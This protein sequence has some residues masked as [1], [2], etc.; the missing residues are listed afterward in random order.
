M[1][2]APRSR[3]AQE[4][5]E[6]P[7]DTRIYSASQRGYTKAWGR[8]KDYSVRQMASET[9][10]PFCQYCRVVEATTIDHALPPKRLAV[11]G[12]VEY[13]RQFADRRYWIPVCQRCNSRKQNLLPP[14]LQ[15]RYPELYARLVAVLLTRG[16]NLHGWSRQR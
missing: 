12:S 16:I 11:V 6:R 15:Q 3:A 13:W 5:S 9:W 14:E 4:V 1:P 8:D 2:M 10:D 7:R